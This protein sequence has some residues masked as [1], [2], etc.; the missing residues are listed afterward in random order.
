MSRPTNLN[1]RN[2][3]EQTP[4]GASYVTG[5]TSETAAAIVQASAIAKLVVANASH[6]NLQ[7]ST[8]KYANAAYTAEEGTTTL[9]ETLMKYPSDAI[10]AG[11]VTS[12][13]VANNPNITVNVKTGI[14]NE[15]LPMRVS[16]NTA[17]ACPTPKGKN[18][19]A[20]GTTSARV[21]RTRML[22]DTPTAVTFI[23]RSQKCVNKLSMFHDFN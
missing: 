10:T 11:N 20:T 2:P 18:V 7:S 5:Q 15:I 12:V 22:N 14:Y 4:A 9:I 16:R 3:D 23:E 1:L 13:P 17:T 6:T 8:P 19:P 21:N